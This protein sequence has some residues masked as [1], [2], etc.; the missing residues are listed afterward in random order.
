MKWPRHGRVA[1]PK[2]IRE[3]LGLEPDD[4]LSLSLAEGSPWARGFYQMF[5]AAT[6]AC[7]AEPRRR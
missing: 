2:Q 4:M 1:I 3:A 7:G 5:A 6:K